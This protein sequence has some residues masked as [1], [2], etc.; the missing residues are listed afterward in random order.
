MG[1]G[2]K[3]HVANK[4][5]IRKQMH[6]QL[7]ELWK[8]H[9]TLI[10]MNSF[11]QPFP[12]PPGAAPGKVKFNDSMS[13]GGRG[14]PGYT[15]VQT[16]ANRFDR[17]GFRFVPLVSK[18]LDLVCSLNVLFLRRENPGDLLTQ[19]GDIDNRIKTLFDALRIPKDGN[20]LVGQPEADENPFFCLLEDDCLVTEINVTTDRLLTPLKEN[21]HKN[22]VVLVIQAKIKTVKLS[23]ENLTLL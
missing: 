8:N 12:R 1:S 14:E 19:G 17:C 18:E 23:L 3:P 7:A 16:M 6:K 21:Q 4:H 5:A 20:E 10:Q 9:P 22:E 2:N 15:Y 13:R 11:V